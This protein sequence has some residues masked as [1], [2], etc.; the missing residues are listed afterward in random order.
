MSGK[1]VIILDAKDEFSEELRAL[2]EALGKAD[3]ETEQLADEQ[4][5]ATKTQRALTVA[6]KA[7]ATALGAVT[8]AAG[9]TAAAITGLLDAG[10]ALLEDWRE[11]EGVNTR[12]A[13]SLTRAGVKQDELAAKMAAYSAIAG[14]VAAETLFGDEAIFEGISKFIDLTGNAEVSTA[15]LNVILG[16]ASDKKVEA[17]QAA[18]LYAKAL[19]GEVGPLKDLTPL[20]KEQ[21]AALNGMTNASERAKRVQEI[22]AAQFGETARQVNPTFNAIKN[23]QDVT[24]DLR[25]AMGGLIDT[26]GAVPGILN[27]I[28]SELRSLEAWIG[29]NDKQARLLTIAFL[30]GLVVAID[31]LLAAGA[32]GVKIL[33][34][35]WKGGE[36]LSL[37]FSNA[38]EFVKQLGH[39]LVAFIS[40]AAA[41]ALRK[42]EDLARDGAQLANLVGAEDLAAKLQRGVDS[43]NKL[44]TSAES[45]VD[46]AF[47]GIAKSTAKV[48]ANIDR[49][50]DAL[51]EFVELSDKVD[52]GL[53]A[54]RKTTSAIRDNLAKARKD[55]ESGKISKTPVSEKTKPV[56]ASTKKLDGVAAAAKR[57]EQEIAKM[58]LAV[59]RETNERTRAKLELAVKLKEVEHQKLTGAKKDLAVARAQLDYKKQLADLDTKLRKE[60]A[61]GEVARLELQALQATN[62]E[63]R[64]ALEYRAKLVALNAQEM[65]DAE[66]AL[67]LERLRREESEA[68]AKAVANEAKANADALESMAARLRQVGAANDDV[69]RTSVQLAGLADLVGKVERHIASVQEGSATAGEA[70][71]A[72]LGSTAGVLGGVFDALGVST[73]E[74]ALLQG[75]F[76][77]AQAL[78][79]FWT[80]DPIRGVGLQA[81]AA[82]HFAVAS[83]AGGTGGGASGGGVSSSGA[84][85]GGGSQGFSA[86]PEDTAQLAADQIGASVAKHIGERGGDTIINFNGGF[87]GPGA[88]REL[89][90]MVQ[91]EQ[92]RRGVA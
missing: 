78:L 80:G 82:A 25:Q 1:V 91:R 15:Q 50:A 32:E 3:D 18:E 77:Q 87:Y 9:L 7:G 44:R 27:P 84:L 43:L 24:G 39:G 41:T 30:D 57:H 61:A 2:L 22:L 64:V 65:T 35:L 47:D 23:L 70:A 29:K 26:S 63:R 60:T 85:S 86:R 37:G 13:Q 51:I 31:E 53:G 48:E 14:Q 83:K 52:K 55:V 34:A 92:R 59:L 68:R 33:L 19:K 6:T 67:A 89:T 88:E 74:Q 38:T 54:V 42:L 8:L 28:T 36:L 17:G 69:E 76:A 5:R 20:T 46:K 71:V 45:G 72:A 11:Q 10:Q 75:F 73:K 16:I 90:N 58:Q 66:R 49:G 12:L 4:E 81:A 56:T 79:A 21:E 62:E 40:G